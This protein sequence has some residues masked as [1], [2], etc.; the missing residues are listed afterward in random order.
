MIWISI[1]E[2][3]IALG[4]KR[5]RAYALARIHRWRTQPGTYP[6]LYALTDVRDTHT[7]RGR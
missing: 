1:D 4:V 3:A 6:R 7:K 5:R 2:A